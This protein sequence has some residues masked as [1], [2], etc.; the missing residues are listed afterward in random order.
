MISDPLLFLA[1]GNFL[2]CLVHSEMYFFKNFIIN[3]LEFV[4]F[5]ATELFSWAAIV[6]EVCD[7]VVF[8]SRFYVGCLAHVFGLFFSYLWIKKNISLTHYALFHCHLALSILS[9]R[10]VFYL[11]VLYWFKG[12]ND[13]TL[14][15]FGH[16]FIILCVLYMYKINVQYNFYSLELFKDTFEV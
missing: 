4:H 5:K 15:S 2:Y 11:Q 13:L 12:I 9:Y 8:I 3:Y 7:F 14:Y 16:S 10:G 6:L 1:P